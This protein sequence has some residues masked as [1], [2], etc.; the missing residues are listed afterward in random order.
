MVKNPEPLLVQGFFHTT[1]HSICYVV[2]SLRSRRCFV[3]DPVRDFDAVSGR[4]GRVLVDEIIAFM[5]HHN[6]TL[7]AILETHVHADHLSGASLLRDI[8]GGWIGI[9][10]GVMDVRRSFASFYDLDQ[11]SFA[12]AFPFDRLF[13]DGDIIGDDD[14]QARVIATPG[15]TPSCI[16]YLMEQNLFVGDTLFMPD[17]GTARCDF[18]GG[19][20]SQLYHSIQR[21]FA[22]PSETKIF[23]CHDYCPNGRSV[24]WETTVGE[25]KLHNIHIKE[26]ISQAA[27]VKLRTE[28][29]KTLSL[30]N[31]MLLAIQVN[32]QAGHLPDPND[33]G[34]RHLKF[35]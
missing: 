21:I 33:R 28:R 22:L 3:I 14:L 6:L 32:V 17:G 16:S 20:A 34:I 1:T 24:A 23:V 27:F 31:L 15:H 25:E 18:P 19:D 4:T 30:P 12:Q 10:K 29:D 8:L 7:E 13:D 5:Q 11:E 35:P 26:G 9:S 2:A